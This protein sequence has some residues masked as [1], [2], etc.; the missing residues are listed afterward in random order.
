MEI[1]ALVM[2]RLAFFANSFFART[3][4]S[5]VLRGFGHHVA[6]QTHGDSSRGLT[7]DGHVEVHL[8]GEVFGWKVV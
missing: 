2:K 1:G 4:R 6:V 3:Q 8:F 7:S 5:E